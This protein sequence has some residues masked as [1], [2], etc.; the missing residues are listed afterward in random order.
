MDHK[1]ML[2]AVWGRKRNEIVDELRRILEKS[3]DAKNV[4]VEGLSDCQ[5]ELKKK[6]QPRYDV[7]GRP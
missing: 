2:I 1:A 6:Y 7:H 5:R 3:G 4:A